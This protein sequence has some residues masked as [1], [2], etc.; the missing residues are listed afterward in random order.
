MVRRLV[1]PAIAS[2]L[3]LLASVASGQFTG[4]IAGQ[5]IDAES[6]K[7]LPGANVVVAG[8]YMG[9]AT[10]DRGWYVILN[11]PPG[12]YR[13]Q[14]FYLGYARVVVE[15]VQV[16]I[17]RTAKVDVKMQPTVLDLG[18][19]ITVTATRPIVEA[20]KTASSVHFDESQVR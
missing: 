15:G 11:V 9:A 6:G 13:L 1:V 7:P 16:H 17:D 10:D 14:I 4:K 18:Q 19:T 3:S 2:A 12:V 8:T 20:D 5:V